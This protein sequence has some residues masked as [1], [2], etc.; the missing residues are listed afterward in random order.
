VTGFGFA[1]G[2]HVSSIRGGNYRISEYAAAIGLAVLATIEQKVARL[3]SV[4][5]CYAGALRNSRIRLQDGVG[6]RWAT[7][8]LNVLLPPECV[9]DT[10]DTLDR[11]GVEWRRWW[12][13]GCHTHP[14]FAEVASL[15][16]PVTRDLA[17]RLIGVPCHTELSNEA[18]HT[19]CRQLLLGQTALV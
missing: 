17:P 12:G 9:E 16:L 11:A 5:R 15:P 3:Q 4:T 7:M 19:T 6:E 13:L 18:V 14:A 10:L 2:S 1:S 8:T